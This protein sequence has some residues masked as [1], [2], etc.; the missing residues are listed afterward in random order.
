MWVK[1]PPK[2]QPLNSVP[3]DKILDC[4]KFKAFADDSL[5]VAQKKFVS[6]IGLKTLWEKKKMLGTTIFCLS[7]NF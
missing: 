5:Y 6:L 1:T 2:Q 4:S 7:H 3:K